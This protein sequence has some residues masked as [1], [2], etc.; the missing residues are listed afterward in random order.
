MHSPL[1]ALFFSLLYLSVLIRSSV[2]QSTYWLA[3]KPNLGHVAFQDPSYPVFRNVKDY[4]AVGD[5]L[6]DDS[7]AINRA[8]AAPGNRCGGGN[9][10]YGSFC[11][12]STITP[13]L[14]YFPPG[15]YN[16]SKPL[17]MYYFTQMVGD[18][19]NPPTIRVSSNFTN[20]IGLA[21]FDAD[22]Y[23]PSGSGAEWYANQNNFYRQVRNFIIDMTNAPLKTAGI[24]WQVA[25]ATSLQN[26][27]INMVSKDV[28]NNQQQ[29][30]YMENG[31]GGFFSDM[32]IT[33][34][35]IGA[36]L[37]NQQFT[38]R[39]IQFDGCS[40][41]IKM[42]FDWVWLF[43]Q[44][45]ITNSDVGI[46]MTSGGF[47]NL[48]VGS[49]LLI[50]SVI[51]ATQGIL[52]PYAPGF[53]SPQAAGT[54]VLE[55]VDFTG[56]DVAISAAGG[57]Q[58]RTILAG[59][60]F[61]DLWAQGNAW[62]TAGQ[63]L[64]GQFFNGTACVYQNAS[65]TAY[66]AQETTVQR[67]L[68]PIPRPSSLVDSNGQ[69]VYRVKPQ[70]ENLQWSTGFLSAKANGLVGDGSTDDTAAMQALFNLAYTTGRVAYFDRG[71]YIVTSTINVP[72]DVKITGELL[73]IIMATGPF[74]GDQFNPQPMWKIG[75]PGEVGTV[76]ISDLV[77]EVKG[78]CPGAILIE[79]NIKG[80]GPAL[81]GIW[82]AHWRIGGSAGTN[83]QQ[84][85]CIKTPATPIA[86]SNSVLTDC[87]GAFL[88]LHVT[89]QA[90]GYFEN[91][92]GWVAD[93]ELDLAD[94]QQIYIFNKGGFLIESQGPVWLYGTAAEHS[95]MYDYQFVNAKN[96]FMG[97]IQHET[98]YFQGNPN[99]LVP[100]TPQASWHDPDYS[101]CVQTNCARTWGLRF[102]NSSQIFM[103]GGGLYNFFENW[104]TQACLGTE[105]CQERMVD[106]RNSTD[107]YL[108][109]LSTKGSQFMISYEGTDVVPYSVNKAN[110]CET[111]ALFELA[112]EQ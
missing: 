87:I 19:V 36:Y 35:S 112:S 52:T 16:V 55:K 80:A 17:I 64:N 78:P 107:I 32:V 96:V 100:F 5:G 26:I 77:F 66:T 51:S 89:S 111:V 102:V 23:I 59:Q 21:V 71:A 31:S 91:I 101:D 46:D 42:N 86:G 6:H 53:S 94:R 68:A 27:A 1:S 92:W 84:D 81:A 109:A 103:Y 93:H 69:Y 9:A 14:V 37:G 90:D 18:A 29:G 10:T 58:A 44:I 76:E 34:G 74:F 20:I 97:H 67:A 39:K 63:A 48:A 88:L 104:N 45:T 110:F 75:N 50:D 61:V 65:Q 82:D 15:T 85:R 79:W 38:T 57:T 47:S 106:F 30:I 70:Y 28:V 4:G 33:G 12:S 8:I 2:A 56:S 43:S 98:A 62:T 72:T 54:L 83:L 60:Q 7:D 41:A 99:A 24:H 105:S 108:W 49:L 73:S 11:Q 40:T 13:A 22:I 95:V 3:N 25:Q